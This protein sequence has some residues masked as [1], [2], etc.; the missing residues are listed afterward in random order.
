MRTPAMIIA[1]ATTLLLASGCATV[2]RGTTDTL[3]IQSE[4]AG[5]EIEL[6]SGQRCV[7]PCSFE[8]QRKHDI[9]L[10]MRKAGYRDVEIQVE[11][12]VV[13]A[14]A[15]GMAG[16][17]LIGGIIG[18]GI[19]AVTGATHSLKPNPVH[20]HLVVLDVADADRLCDAANTVPGAICRGLL[21]AGATRDAVQQLLGPPQ[22]Q[23]REGR[24]WQYGHDT[25]SL[26][27]ANQMHESGRFEST[28]VV[29]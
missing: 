1:S 7:T 11:S 17:V 15:A 27:L 9:R 21:Q 5:A 19:D 6:S 16:N 4:P 8:L 13:A 2:T 10:F 29:K 18:V 24:E 3:H 22:E 23:R 26:D 14:G 25:P 20:V 28:I 12:E